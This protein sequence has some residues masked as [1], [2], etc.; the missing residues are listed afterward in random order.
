[1][2]EL[3]SAAPTRGTPRV[4]N[5]SRSTPTTAA[6]VMPRAVTADR[7][8]RVCSSTTVRIFIGRP[9]MVWSFTKSYV[10][11]WSMCA[12]AWRVTPFADVPK[13]LRLCTFR[14]TFSPCL[15]HSRC[16]R[17]RP[18]LNPSASSIA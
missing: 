7:H 16:T 6:A 5:N 2:V 9:S 1:M 15:R 8:S 13:R 4:T 11:T 10:H 14:G 18:V 17:S 12:A 3:G